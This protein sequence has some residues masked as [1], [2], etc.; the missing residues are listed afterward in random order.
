MLP[1]L[2]TAR[3]VL[4]GWDDADRAP[5]AAL[6][7]DPEVV[8]HLPGPLSREESDALIDRL[9]AHGEAHGFALW[10]VEAEDLGFVGFA[11]LN[12]PNF[13]TAFTPCVEIGWRLARHAWG[14][15]YAT[16]A[17]REALRFGFEEA[18][19]HEILS[20]TVPANR[21]SWRVMERVGMT[22]R[23]PFRFEHPRLPEGHRLR[24]HVL[25][26]IERP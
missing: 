3:L 5:F 23:A 7:A 15:G 13:E 6:N 1:V 24:E 26:G 16:E 11:G 17:A 19:L 4:R 10:A 8:E 9:V 20:W 12:V 21:R 18:G 22:P 2:R 25:Y 14:R